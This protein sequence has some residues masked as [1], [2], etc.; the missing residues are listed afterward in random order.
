MKKILILLVPFVLAGGAGVV[1][2]QRSGQ[3]STTFRTAPV[4]RGDLLVTISATGTV[5]PEEV[6]DVGAQIAGRIASFGHD[7]DAPDKTIDY[8]SAV[9]EGT[10]LARID[11]ALYAADVESSAAQ[12]EQVKANVLRAQADLE[13][14]KA[15]LY[16]AEQNWKRAQELGPSRALSATDYDS[17]QAAYETA[18]ATVA[19][20]EATIVQ[21]EKA[22]LQ[23]QA[24]LDRTK[25]NLGYCTI[26]SPVKGVIVDR[27][28]NIGQ[29]VV[30][31]LSAP[32]IFLI[33]K[34]LKRMQVW[35]SVNEADIGSI[36]AGQP[37][38]F[39]V[40]AYPGQRFRGEVG[41]IRLNASMTQNVVTYT[42]EITTDNSDGRLLPY[43]T[44]NVQFEITRRPDVLMVPNAALRW[45]PVLQ[46][47]VPDARQEL[48]NTGRR[49]PTATRP[50][51]A[52]GAGAAAAARPPG[53]VWI[54][55][56]AYVRPIAVKVGPSDGAMTEVQSDRLSEGT[57]VVLS[58]AV[59]GAAS[60]QT[61][62]PFT[63]Q[64][65]G[66]RR[67]Q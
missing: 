64:V 56:G 25:T 48:G 38:S 26:K 63:P 29:T 67:P 52:A 35:A 30:A 53:A 20:G 2:W 14:M 36:H 60:A 58:E 12:L 49:R 47:V 28:V 65:F 4:K 45:T 21:A 6:V 27:R 15:K 54:Q 43:L 31:S 19:V 44:A 50:A 37:V 24:S 18:K 62:N 39:T 61:V 16:Q 8:G 66:N 3:P 9:A 55:D 13:Q 23:A 59:R 57:E 46:Q 41:K 1:Y 33:A 11:D 17:Y 40:D 5:E 51:A 32:S 22:V 10:V 34:D 7:P 42:V